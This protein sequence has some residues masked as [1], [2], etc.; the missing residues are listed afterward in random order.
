MNSGFKEYNLIVIIVFT[1]KLLMKNNT[2]RSI[3]SPSPFNVKI[4]KLIAVIK[5]YK[6]F[7]NLL[8]ELFCNA[9]D[10]L[11]FIEKNKFITILIV[12]RKTLIFNLYISFTS[13]LKTE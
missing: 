2:A 10:K 1:I 8:N 9:L 4:V 5:T 6:K 13:T 12:T 3:N 7:L 11:K